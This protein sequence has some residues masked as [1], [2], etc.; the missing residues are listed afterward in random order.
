MTGD[1]PDGDMKFSVDKNTTCPGHPQGTIIIHYNMYAGIRDGK[2][3]PGTSR[4]GYLP[5]TPE[6]K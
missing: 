3:F 4:T 5:Y 2:N 6:G 1:Q